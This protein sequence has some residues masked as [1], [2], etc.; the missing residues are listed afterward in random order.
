VI[1]ITC[2]GVGSIDCNLA[3]CFDGGK[4]GWRAR[5]GRGWTRGQQVVYKFF[6]CLVAGS[7]FSVGADL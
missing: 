3:W 6:S 5:L 4:H 2:L 1:H 7:M